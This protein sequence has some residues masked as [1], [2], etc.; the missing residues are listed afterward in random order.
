MQRL[1]AI[2]LKNYLA[3]MDATILARTTDDMSNYD[4]PT[5][6]NTTY[7]LDFVD[8]IRNARDFF[9]PIQYAYFQPGVE[10][11]YGRSIQCSYQHKIVNLIADAEQ[12]NIIERKK[13]D[14]DAKFC[15][16]VCVVDNTKFK[17]DVLEKVKL[18]AFI[19]RD[20]NCGRIDYS[21]VEPFYPDTEK[22]GA[23]DP[24]DL[25]HSLTNCDLPHLIHEQ[26]EYVRGWK[27]DP[28]PVFQD[29]RIY[30][31][32][33]LY[34]AMA[35]LHYLR[36]T[37]YEELEQAVGTDGMDLSRQIANR[38]FDLKKAKQH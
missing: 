26:I 36:F 6:P 18:P 22:T 12:E 35:A 31:A 27:L 16:G 33:I 2:K 19:N 23:L 24:K 13:I 21:H 7:E 30:D 29:G 5:I 14:K 1:Y 25:F 17:T 38:M 8:S 4:K 15:S 34:G 28:Y 20:R 3:I 37:N 9:M 32:D 10:Q 11:P